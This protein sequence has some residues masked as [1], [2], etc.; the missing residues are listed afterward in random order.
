MHTLADISPLVI[1]QSIPDNIT[2]S[3]E[4]EGQTSDKNKTHIVILSIPGNCTKA[5]CKQLTR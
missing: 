1:D 5:E 4:G 3:G 2:S